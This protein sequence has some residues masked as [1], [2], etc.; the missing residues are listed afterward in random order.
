MKLIFTCSTKDVVPALNNDDLSELAGAI[1]QALYDYLLIK[2][3]EDSDWNVE[4][5][6][7]P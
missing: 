4:V 5:E 3:D 2:E 1:Q 6:V 7:G